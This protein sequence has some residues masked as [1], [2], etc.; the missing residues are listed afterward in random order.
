[1]TGLY[2]E[3][4]L[5]R[6]GGKTLIYFQD[7]LRVFTERKLPSILGTSDLSSCFWKDLG[8][9]CHAFIVY[10]IPKCVRNFSN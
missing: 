9:A 5:S 3:M 2:C 7:A 8:W 1:M 6:D 4:K 10:N